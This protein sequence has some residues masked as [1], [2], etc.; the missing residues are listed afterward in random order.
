M[1]TEYGYYNKTC[2]ER[3]SACL[4][5]CT[6]YF[7]GLSAEALGNVIIHADPGNGRS[8][9]MRWRNR[10]ARKGRMRKKIHK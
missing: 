4:C 1:T 6:I 2:V 8:I 3:T 7:C 5:I 10:K 9:P